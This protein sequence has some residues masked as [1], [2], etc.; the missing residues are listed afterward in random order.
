MCADQLEIKIIT[1]APPPLLKK[2]RNCDEMKSVEDFPYFSCSTAGRKNTCKTCSQEL[3]NLRRK[4]RLQNPPPLEGE[5]PIC[6]QHTNDWILDHCHFNDSFRGYI[7]NGCNLGLGRF[8][9][10]PKLLERAIKYL[11]GSKT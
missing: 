3:S 9:D 5:C 2:C 10:D 1:D 4:L 6:N 7:C 11:N 8:N